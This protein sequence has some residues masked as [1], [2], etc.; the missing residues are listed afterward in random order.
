MLP[1]VRGQAEH[2]RPAATPVGMMG[3]MARA[4]SGQRTE[5]EEVRRAVAAFVAAGADESVQRVV[6]AVH[7]LSRRLDQWYDRQLADID[8]S[9]GEWAVLSELARSGEDTPLTPSQLAVAANV[10]PSSMTH[11]LD[12]MVQRGLIE[13]TP[14]PGNRTRVLVRLSDAG[15]ALYAAAIRESD[16]VESD[17]LESLSDAEI[18]QLALLL[19]KVLSGLDGVEP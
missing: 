18:D 1:A 5:I 3:A 17:L 6:T 16:M 13:R 9:T 15:Y 10:A 12:R 8:V 11:R 19:E 7:R 14:D 4:K 2:W